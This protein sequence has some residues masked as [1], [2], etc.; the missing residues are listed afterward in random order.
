M[1]NILSYLII[2]N[3]D[4]L[5][6]KVCYYYK[7]DFIS[8]WGERSKLHAIKISRFKEQITVVGSARFDNY[9]KIRNE[10][11][12]KIFEKNMSFF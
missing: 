12:P 7:P 1:K 11:I 10:N 2:D 4:N 6:S 5:S 9:F 8:T 3:W